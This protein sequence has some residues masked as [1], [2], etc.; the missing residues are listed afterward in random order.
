[1]EDDEQRILSGRVEIGSFW[2]QPRLSCLRET[3]KKRPPLVW[4]RSSW[5]VPAGLKISVE[6]EQKWSMSL[7]EVM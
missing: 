5:V 1:V 7:A 2:K 3:V 4:K 6:D